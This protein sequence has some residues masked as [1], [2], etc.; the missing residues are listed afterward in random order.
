MI[1]LSVADYCHKCP[2]FSPTASRLYA[3]SEIYLTKVFC[4][5]ANS[6]CLIETHIRKEL[7]KEKEND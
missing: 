6:C 7:E 1:E 3:G 4:E 2:R 5:Y